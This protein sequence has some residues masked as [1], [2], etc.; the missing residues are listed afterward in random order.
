[1]IHWNSSTTEVCLNPRMPLEMKEFLS[2]ALKQTDRF[3]GHVWIATSGTSGT[4]KWVLLS[5]KAM[6]CSAQAVN[7]HLNSQRSDIWLNPLP[8]FHVGGLGI[9]ARSHV[10]EATVVK[11]IFSNNR[12][13]SRQFIEQLKSTRATLTALVPAQVFDL[14]ACNL[15]APPHLRAV[16]VGG[17]A[18]SQHL[19]EKAIALG[20]KLLPS[21]GLTECASQV[22]TAPLGSTNF[23][24]LRPLPHVKLDLDQY[25]HLTI[26]SESL[27][28]AYV[29]CERD[30]IRWHDPKINGWLTTEDHAI[31]EN[32]EIKAITRGVNFIKIGG[33]SVDVMRLERILEE[34]VLAAK[35]SFD[36]ALIAMSDERLGYQIHLV[37][38]T[39]K[40]N[41]VRELTERFR[42]RVLPYEAIRKIHHVEAIPRSPL[43]KVLKEELKNLLLI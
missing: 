43:G 19:Y 17:G 15:T 36:T 3:P 26:F 6:L 5:K 32:G 2:G 7:T 41:L 27:L 14:V 23:P 8:E 16:I 24:S 37:A 9:Q 12:W 30:Q 31:F 38:A 42:Q 13:D 34:E 29:Y 33:E 39:P 25:G 35:F 22:A 1:M 21:Y 4:P 20:W 10:S 18:Q 28:T 11:C 40:A